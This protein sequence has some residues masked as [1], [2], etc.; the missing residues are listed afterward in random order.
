MKIKEIKTTIEKIKLKTPFVTSLRRV[1]NVEFVRV[2]V[3]ADHGVVSIGEAPATK[4]ITGEDLISIQTAVDKNKG[5]FRG[6]EVFESFELLDSLNIGSSAKAA[7]DMAFYNLLNPI[8]NQTDRKTAITISFG[9]TKKMLFDANIAVSANNN[10]LKVKFSKDIQHAIEVTKKIKEQNPGAVIYVDANQAWSFEDTMF[11]I[12]SIDKQ[13]IELIEQPV[14]KDDLDSLK[15]ITHYS[16]IPIVADESCFNIDEVKNIV[17]NHIADVINIKLM[18][19]GGVTKAIEILEYCASKK[20]PVMMGSML[21]GPTSIKYASSL[22]DTYKEVV[23]YIDLD[24][25]LL[26]DI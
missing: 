22:A 14:Q 24:S 5:K 23:K 19:C 11:Y 15:A 6:V 4:A 10:I 13:Y 20:V 2:Y 25:P 8:K 9:N 18:K 16:N 17:E 21:E 12:D 1:E 3:E 26:Y 7:L